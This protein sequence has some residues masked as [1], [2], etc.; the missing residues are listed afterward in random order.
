MLLIRHKTQ[1]TN[2]KIQLLILLAVP[3]H[4]GVSGVCIWHSHV[5]S[6]PSG[7]VSTSSAPHTLCAPS[8]RQRPLADLRSHS[9]HS[10]WSRMTDRMW[11]CRKKILNNEKIIQHILLF[12]LILFIYYFYHHQWLFETKTKYYLFF[13]RDDKKKK[14]IEKHVSYYTKITNKSNFASFF[15]FVKMTN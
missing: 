12:H 13:T 9:T 14:K 3:E 15:P 4:A 7:P 5:S 1:Q 8:P 10:I 11:T 2:F 6:L